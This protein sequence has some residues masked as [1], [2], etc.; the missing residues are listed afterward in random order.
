MKESLSARRGY[1]LVAVYAMAVFGIGAL[2]AVPVYKWLLGFGV[3]LEALHQW[4]ADWLKILALAAIPVLLFVA[5][6]KWRDGLGLNCGGRGL[7]QLSMGFVFGAAT[8]AIT[9]TALLA[10]EVRVP[11]AGLD[12]DVL[13][14]ALWKAALTAV[15]VS[16]IEELWFRGA[17]HRVLRPAGPVRAVCI[18]AC[19]YAAL[20]FLRPDVPVAPPHVVFD[21]LSAVAGLFARFDDVRYFDSA[22]ALLCVGLVL[23]TLRVHFGCIAACIGAHA[24][25]VFVLQTVRRTTQSEPGQWS[26]LAGRYDGI[27]GWGFIVVTLLAVSVV[28]GWRARLNAARTARTLA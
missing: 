25:W 5:R 8:M 28:Y 17:L 21:G 4:T 16:I 19:I 7:R 11:R 6:C 12:A 9:C 27:I 10:L 24:G 3:E 2:T 13:V 26:W 15:L 14:A 1:G 22:L 18:V 20:H 23:G